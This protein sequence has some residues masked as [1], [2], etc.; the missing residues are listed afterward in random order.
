[1]YTEISI[2]VDRLSAQHMF[3]RKAFFQINFFNFFILYKSTIILFILIHFFKLLLHAKP[4][5]AFEF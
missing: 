1:M 3:V 5:L 4:V 2:P